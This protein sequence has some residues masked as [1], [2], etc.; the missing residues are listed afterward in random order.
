MK[1]GV[2]KKERRTHGGR[3]SKHERNDRGRD[4]GKDKLN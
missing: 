3:G 4:A 2:G 1:K